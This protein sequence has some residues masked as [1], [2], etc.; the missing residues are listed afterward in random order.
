MN[1][2]FKANPVTNNQEATFTAKLVSDAPK[3]L[4]EY[5]NGKGDKKKYGLVSIE[6]EDA[7]GKKVVRS[8]AIPEANL[9]HGITKGEE[10]LSRVTIVGNQAF[11]SMSHLQGAAR[12]TAEDFGFVGVNAQ[13]SVLATA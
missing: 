4:L 2:E 13:Q 6:F 12:A 5:T 9:A 7:E 10:Y 8:A 11:L 3:N 1:F